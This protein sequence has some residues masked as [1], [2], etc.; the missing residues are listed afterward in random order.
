MKP[1]IFVY[2]LPAGGIWEPDD[3]IGYAVA[4]DGTGLVSHL[5][6]SVGFS[7]HDMGIT[8]NWHHDAYQKHYPDGYELKWIEEKNLDNHEGFQKAFKLNQGLKN[9]EIK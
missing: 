3:V 6:S 7:K 8:S 1:K 5:S 2:C 9:N 4:E